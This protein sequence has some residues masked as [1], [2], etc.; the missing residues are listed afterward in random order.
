MWWKKKDKPTIEEQYFKDVKKGVNKYILRNK[1]SLSNR[2]DA[3]LIE[4]AEEQNIKVSLKKRFVAPY[5]LMLAFSSS[6]FM[7]VAIFISLWILQPQLYLP[8]IRLFAKPQNVQVSMK[9]VVFAERGI[10]ANTKEIRLVS[11]KQLDEKF[12][13]SSVN[14]VPKVDA[15]VTLSQDKKEIIIKPKEELKAGTVYNVTIKSGLVFTDGTY[16]ASDQSWVVPVKHDFS[17]LN[18]VPAQK[19]TYDTSIVITLSSEDVEIEEL[20]QKIEFIP[21]IQGTF[22]KKGAVVTFTPSKALMPGLVYSVTVPETIQNKEGSKIKEAK[23]SQFIVENSTNIEGN[24]VEYTGPSIAFTDEFMNISQNGTVN[25]TTNAVSSIKLEAFSIDEQKL[26]ELFN[27]KAKGELINWNAVISGQKEKIIISSTNVNKT[28]I[29]PITNLPNGIFILKATS[30]SDPF[31]HNFMVI[32]KSNTGLYIIRTATEV[33]VWSYDLES[34]KQK[35]GVDLV[36]YECTTTGC[37]NSINA[38][39][40]DNGFASLKKSVDSGFIVAKSGNDTSFWIVNNL[41]SQITKKSTSTNIFIQEILSETSFEPGDT[42]SYAFVIKERENESLMPAK[43]RKFTM[44]VCNKEA[45]NSGKYETCLISRRLNLDDGGLVKGNFTAWNSNEDIYLVVVEQKD[46]GKEEVLKTIHL[47][48]KQISSSQVQI[49]TDKGNYLSSEKVQVSGIITDSFGRLRANETVSIETYFIDSESKLPVTQQF[50]RT[51]GNGSFKYSANLPKNITTSSAIF[52]VQATYLTDKVSSQVAVTVQTSALNVYAEQSGKVVKTAYVNDPI[53]VRINRFKESESESQITYSVSRRYI[54]QKEVTVKGKKEIVTQSQTEVISPPK[55]LKL[56]NEG[57]LFELKDLQVGDYIV[58][59]SEGGITNNYEA[60]TVPQISTGIENKINYFG[61]NT[62]QAS[63]GEK[64]PLL[65]VGNF[66]VKDKKLLLVTKTGELKTWEYIDAKQQKREFAITRDMVG[67][68]EVCV[69]FP[70]KSGSGV[71]S[72]C[73]YLAVNEIDKKAIVQPKLAKSSY[74]P[75]ES[76]T[77]PVTILNKD[78][79]PVVAKIIAKGNVIN[80]QELSIFDEFYNPKGFSNKSVQ[81]NSVFWN[82]TSQTSND[83]QGNVSFRIPAKISGQQSFYIEIVAISQQGHI[84][85]VIVPI[86]VDPTPYTE[87]YFVNGKA[88]VRTFNPGNTTFTAVLNVTCTECLEKPVLSSLSI[89]AFGSQL[90]EIPVNRVGEASMKLEIKQA[91]LV[92]F[93]SENKI[94]TQVNNLTEN[95]RLLKLVNAENTLEFNLPE[96]IEADKKSVSLTLTRYPFIPSVLRIS[97]SQET[98]NILLNNGITTSYLIHKPELNPEGGRD[99]EIAQRLTELLYKI[100]NKQNING[101]FS[102]SPTNIHATDQIKAAILYKKLND[103]SFAN[104]K[105]Q[106]N[107]NRFIVYLTSQLEDSSVSSQNKAMYLYA[108]SLL[109]KDTAS[110]YTVQMRE[111]SNSNKQFLSTSGA[112]YLAGAFAEVNATADIRNQIELIK[113]DVKF[114]ENTSVFEKALL[115]SILKQHNI[116]LSEEKN[117]TESIEKWFLTQKFNVDTFDIGTGAKLYDSFDYSDVGTLE[118]GTVKVTVNGKE[119]GDISFDSDNYTVKIPA[120]RLNNGK[121]DLKISFQPNKTLFLIMVE[122]YITENN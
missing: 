58:T 17:V 110:Y 6:M 101:S 106:D 116:I 64:V 60:F 50:V 82:D 93:A 47:L 7:I 5:R 23:S 118:K 38:K 122:S 111:S 68:V 18:I 49:F 2:L 78:G 35:V 28:A 16:L 91:D 100:Q 19:A 114:I 9:G 99:G 41:F 62:S 113:S 72:E 90:V 76:V 107:L 52:V 87:V 120:D 71:R 4:K 85:S 3:L 104:E 57:Q 43:D 13:A 74:K 15:E 96:N 69:V 105:Y 80:N 29:L 56:T 98:I 59:V 67:G 92:V 27:A 39:T 54:S 45:I 119:I 117:V 102:D 65:L 8:L 11:D 88:Q 53:T 25:I 51:D 70:D 81:E 95:I 26:L 12:V 33:D 34:E 77:I 79:R 31:Y 42:I 84:G 121:N 48:S 46:S 73:S 10:D 97:E 40:Q 20:K 44:Y 89:A 61:F 1:K 36:L 37:T 21:K 108:L 83:G 94:P 63:V 75:G 66:P 55:T 22:E 103:I 115:L 109:Q 30:I 32:S 24:K 14:I 86:T 112:I